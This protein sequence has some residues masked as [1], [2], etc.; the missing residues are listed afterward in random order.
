METRSADLSQ[1]FSTS[2]VFRQKHVTGKENTLLGMSVRNVYYI[3]HRFA[4][5]NIE[6]APLPIFEFVFPIQSDH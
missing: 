3:V 2:P 4:R 5:N 6:S 1:V